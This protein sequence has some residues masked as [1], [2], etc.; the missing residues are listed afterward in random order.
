MTVHVAGVV[1][2]VVL[3]IG[4]AVQVVRAVRLRDLG[5]AAQGQ[6]LLLAAA[7]LSSISTAA[8]AS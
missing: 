8:A 1:R 2:T 6:G 3:L 5:L 4:G 7:L